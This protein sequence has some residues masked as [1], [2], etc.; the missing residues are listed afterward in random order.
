MSWLVG[1]D[2]AKKAVAM[3]IEV[4]E[5]DIECLPEKVSDGVLSDQVELA[6][7][8]RYLTQDAWLL[9]QDV[10]KQKQ[11]KFGRKYG[12][13]SAAFLD[14]ENSICCDSCLLCQH[15]SCASIVKKPKTKNWFC[16][17]CHRTE[18]YPF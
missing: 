11:E 5:V 2:L 7:V 3:K 17:M 9:V 8:R 18:E 10:M 14:G 13:C 16:R 15:F 6:V 12:A 4:E 1:Q